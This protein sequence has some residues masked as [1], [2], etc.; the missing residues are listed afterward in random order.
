MSFDIIIMAYNC[1][2]TLPRALDSLVQQTD[3]E[4][5]VIVIDDGSEDNPYQIVEKY[6]DKLNIRYLQNESN[7]GVTATRQRSMDE[8]TAEYFAFL[9]ADDVFFP[10]AVEVWKKEIELSQ[11]D[12]IMT[13]VVYAADTTDLLKPA[14]NMIACHGKAYKTE[15][16]K[17]YAIRIHNDVKCVEDVYLNLVALSLAENVSILKDIIYMQIDTASSITHTKKWR[18]ESFRDMRRAIFLA[19]RYVVRFKK[20]LKENYE[21]V[22]N[23]FVQML[24][25]EAE[26][27]QKFINN[28]IL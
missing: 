17:K 25:D 26:N 11:P 14:T 21:Q 15:F 2:Q 20:N 5:N 24:D 3:S 27:H 19:I 12:I 18:D 22:A 7:L 6:M 10:N 1:T 28:I 23:K 13:P 8:T 4:F 9:D 16:L